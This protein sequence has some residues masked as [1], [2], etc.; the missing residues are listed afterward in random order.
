[1]LLWERGWGEGLGTGSYLSVP[2]APVVI[3]DSRAPSS[4]ELDARNTS[5]VH[6]QQKNLFRLAR[7][8]A[9]QMRASRRNERMASR[10]PHVTSW[11]A[12]Q[13]LYSWD[14]RCCKWRFLDRC[15]GMRS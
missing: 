10:K 1:M 15:R 6:C 4:R 8:L 13:H 9:N 14:V 2:Y 11:A 12:C 5:F 7:R 3:N